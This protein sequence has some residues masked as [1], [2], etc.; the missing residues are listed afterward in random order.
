MLELPTD[1]PYTA[2]D[3]YSYEVESYR[4]NV[5]AI[6]MRHHYDYSYSSD[7]VRTIWGFYNTKQRQYYAPINA[8]KC[9]GKVNLSETSAYSA[10]PK[11]YN[12]L[13]AAFA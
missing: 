7:V 6:W 3:N 9:G 8:K 12:P 1:F 11:K 4:S 10:M 5:V 13:M 2:P